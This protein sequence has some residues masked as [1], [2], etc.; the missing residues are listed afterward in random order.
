MSPFN[1]VGYTEIAEK[2]QRITEKK[3]KKEPV[4]D[5]RKNRTVF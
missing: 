4:Y 5:A 2:A 3:R 1:G